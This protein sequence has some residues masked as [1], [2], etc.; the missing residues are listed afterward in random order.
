[1]SESLGIGTPV[2]SYA[3]CIAPDLIDKDCGW[4]VEAGNVKKYS[5]AMFDALDLYHNSPDKLKQ[6]SKNS[7][8]SYH[9]N[10]SME[11]LSKQWFKALEVDQK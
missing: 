2:I 4:I 11:N 9:K 3:D 7:Y 8:D 6:M 5:Q 1:M 10:Y